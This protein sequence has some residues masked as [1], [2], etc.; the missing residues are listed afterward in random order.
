MDDR[1]R[2]VLN[3]ERAQLLA[4]GDRDARLKLQ[5]ARSKTIDMIVPE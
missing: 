2:A 4:P 5:M 3:Y 1:T